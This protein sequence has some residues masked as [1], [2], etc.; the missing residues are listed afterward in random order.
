[1]WHLLCTG[2]PAYPS[3]VFSLYLEHNELPIATQQAKAFHHQAIFPV[4]VQDDP[5]ALYQCQYS[6]LLGSSFSHSEHSHTVAVSK[7]TH[8]GVI[9]GQPTG[10]AGPV[11]WN[12]RQSYSALYCSH[13][14]PSV[15]SVLLLHLY[16]TFGRSEECDFFFFTFQKVVL[17][18]PQVYYN[19]YLQ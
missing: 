15:L 9:R 8:T 16:C 1:M 17:L 14:H 10:S 13:A 6:V 2:S 18:H 12:S 4:P 5:V 7:G 3:A 11:V 19:L